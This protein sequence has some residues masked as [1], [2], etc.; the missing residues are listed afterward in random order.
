MQDVDGTFRI[1]HVQ[2]D[3]G[4]LDE[5]EVALGVLDTARNLGGGAALAD[6]EFGDEW[7]R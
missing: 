1:G 6:A 3:C 5:V 7:G 4:F 2:A